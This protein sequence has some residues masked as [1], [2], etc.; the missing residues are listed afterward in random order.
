[1][2]SRA[3]NWIAVLLIVAAV[4]VT[5]GWTWWRAP[6]RGVDHVESHVPFVPAPPIDFV[7]GAVEELWRAD[8]PLSTG[9]FTVDGLAL[10]A[11]GDGVSALNPA[12]GEEFW[13]YHRDVDLCAAMVSG[14]RVVTVFRGPAGCGEVTSLNAA[15]G[16][17]TATRRSLAPGTVYPVRSNSRAGIRHSR[18]VELWRDD[19]VRTIEYGSVEASPEPDLQPHPGCGVMDAMTRVDLLAV[20]NA[21][22]DGFR[23]VLQEVTPEESRSPEVH[24][25]VELPGPAQLVA[26]SKDRAAVLVDG[27]VVVY[28]LEGR[29]GPVHSP[30]SVPTEAP[31][32]VPEPEPEPGQVEPG[33]PEP[34]QGDVTV[35][36]RPETP[37]MTGDLPHHMTWFTG[38]ELVFMNP[39][40]LSVHFT[41]PGALGP[42]IDVAGRVL[43]PVEGGILVVDWTDGAHGHIIPVDRSGSPEGPVTLAVAGATLVEKRGDEMVGLRPLP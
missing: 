37:A 13:S 22:P 39:D 33:R 18:M 36:P 41:V 15:D 11:T 43:V 9:P 40:D 23:L 28:D 25:D 10:A 29:R 4:A 5:V 14:G 27:E 30:E 3:R 8:A 32:P 38:T 20:V 6:A 35:P 26:I 19:L 21:C 2:S 42:G 31:A 17:Y 24:A 7:P 1:M 12:T 16:S 34:G